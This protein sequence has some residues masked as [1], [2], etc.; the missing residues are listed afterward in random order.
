MANYMNTQTCLLCGLEF[1]ARDLRTELCPSCQ[2]YAPMV[3]KFRG[4]NSR[5]DE[6]TKLHI[7]NSG[8]LRSGTGKRYDWKEKV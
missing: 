8:Y 7:L 5:L 4:Q 3:K 2:G 6:R 1:D